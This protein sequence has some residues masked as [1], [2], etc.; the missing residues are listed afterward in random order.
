VSVPSGDVSVA[1]GHITTAG[2]V[3]GVLT[4]TA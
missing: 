2:T 4:V 1:L 3:T